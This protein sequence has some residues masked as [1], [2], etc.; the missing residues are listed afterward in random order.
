MLLIGSISQQFSGDLK[1]AFAVG[2]S[3]ASFVFFFSLAYGAKLL[4]PIM[5]S[6]TSWRILD[7]LIS[8]IMFTIA[9]K[10]AFLG[11]WL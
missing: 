9:I 1:I 4:L 11:N 6:T 8:F 3:L 5:K 2:A 10:L 7:L